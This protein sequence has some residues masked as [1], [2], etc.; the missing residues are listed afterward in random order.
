MTIDI[1]VLI[2][3]TSTPSGYIRSDAN[4]DDWIWINP[5]TGDWHKFNIATGQYDIVIP[6]ALHDHPELNDINFTGTIS[7]GGE[8]GLTGSKVLDGKRLTFTNG[9]LTGYEVV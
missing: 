7:V 2:V 9:I 8:A 4:Q 6:V 3:G 5:E 1:G